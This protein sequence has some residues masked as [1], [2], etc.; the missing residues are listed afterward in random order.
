MD[1]PLNDLKQALRALRK[2]PVFAATVVLTLAIGIGANT[3][4]F[5]VFNAVVLAPVPF[6]EPDRLVQ[7]V[8]TV[9]GEP[10]DTGISPPTYWHFR[11]QTDVIEDVGAYRFASVNYSAGDALERLP[12]SQVTEPYFRTFRASMALGRPFVADED[13]PGRRENRSR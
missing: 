8:N 7:L 2:S 1:A 5:S 3:A 12:V 4:I 10:N 11:A 13:L 6:P 9:N